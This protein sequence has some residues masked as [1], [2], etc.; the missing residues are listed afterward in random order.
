MQMSV[1]AAGLLSLL[2]HGVMLIFYQRA[3]PIIYHCHY[4]GKII[5]TFL[6]LV[7]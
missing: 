1:I 3:M 5:F 4:L 2:C 7:C 6:M